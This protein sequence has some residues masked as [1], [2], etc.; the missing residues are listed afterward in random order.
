[1]EPVIDRKF[2]IYS[3][4][5]FSMCMSIFFNLI[6]YLVFAIKNHCEVDFIYQ[7]C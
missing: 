6:F 5:Y 7:E 3:F 1:M 4:P 2:L